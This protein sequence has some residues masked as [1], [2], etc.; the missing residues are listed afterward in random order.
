LFQN[1]GPGKKENENRREKNGRKKILTWAL[2]E[3]GGRG[4]LWRGKRLC[5]KEPFPNKPKKKKKKNK[6]WIW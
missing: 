6:E 4:G 1:A 2:R 3:R 5:P